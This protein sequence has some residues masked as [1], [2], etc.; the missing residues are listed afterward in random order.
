LDVIYNKVTSSMEFDDTDVSVSLT[1]ALVRQTNSS[2]I[3]P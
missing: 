3:A 1:L 2:P